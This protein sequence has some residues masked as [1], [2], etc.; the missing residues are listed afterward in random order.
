MSMAWRALGAV[1]L[2]LCVGSSADAA[3]ARPDRKAPT[4]AEQYDLGL[5][6][7]Q[8]GYYVKALEQ[9]NRIR[10]YHR[11]D[12]LA[13]RAELAIADLHYKKAEWDQA[14][15]AYE[16]F[17]RMHPRHPEADY[18]VQRIGLTLYKK[19]PKAAGR[20]QTLTR[21]AVNTWSGFDSRFP[22]S[23]H[24]D[25]VVGLLAECRERLARK[26]LGIAE[27]YRGRAAWPAVEGRAAGLL[28][29]H[30]GSPY[31]ADALVLLV[32]SHAWQGEGVEATKALDKL[33]EVDAARVPE[34][35]RRLSR[36][37]PPARD[38]G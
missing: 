36:A 35:E 11:D 2:W 29:D 18:V 22:E 25:E 34:A 28:V 21:Q 32:E 33:R 27:F 16:D 13:M 12:P 38:G 3:R 17:L 20:D 10:N 6:Y 31:D 24:K 19:A 23:V 30:G 26:E 4:V 1:V 15:L 14:R 7:M 9:F 8:R 5:K 37:R